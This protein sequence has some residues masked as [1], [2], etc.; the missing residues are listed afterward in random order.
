MPTRQ[1]SDA[2]TNAYQT[3][4]LSWTSAG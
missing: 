2:K 3:R 4:E 1:P